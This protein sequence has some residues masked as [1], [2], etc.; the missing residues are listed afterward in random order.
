MKK[1]I[2]TLSVLIIF[3]FVGGLYYSSAQ[4]DGLEPV[5]AEWEDTVHS[6]FEATGFNLEPLSVV[7]LY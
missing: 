2:I 3:G 4:T 5:S 7:P 6:S 1:T